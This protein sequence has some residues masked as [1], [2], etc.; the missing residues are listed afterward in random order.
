M[1]NAFHV[2][3]P[4]QQMS[5]SEMK[6]L[7]RNK[8]RNQKQNKAKKSP[9]HEVIEANALRQSEGAP[10]QPTEAHN[11]RSPTI[12]LTTQARPRRRGPILFQ[13]CG[14]CAA[15]AAF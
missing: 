14:A 13:N 8:I 12:L 15:A 3:I 6:W 7:T 10:K 11:S 4:G 5:M 2:I 9:N 1:A